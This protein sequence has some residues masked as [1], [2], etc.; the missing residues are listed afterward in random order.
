MEKRRR[1]KWLP[2][3]AGKKIR[4]E[5][6]DEKK[7]GE[8]GNGAQGSRPPG[9][10]T[11][12]RQSRRQK[13]ARAAQEIRRPKTGKENPKGLMPSGPYT[14]LMRMEP[15]LFDDPRSVEVVPVDQE[16]SV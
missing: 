14:Q 11:V 6:S 5:V 2:R 8:A 16:G 4:A 3:D 9:T 15:F 13:G 7:P 1:T 10:E 12:S